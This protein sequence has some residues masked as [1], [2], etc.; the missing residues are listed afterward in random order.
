M[1]LELK[2]RNDVW[3]VHGTVVRPDGKR[4]RVRKSTGYTVHQK[5][6]ASAALSRILLE[7]MNAPPEAEVEND[8]ATLDDA[9]D[10]YL[11]RPNPPGQTE[12]GHLMRLSKAMGR[13][14]LSKV[15]LHSL[16]VYVTQR[17][18][19]PGT[20]AREMNSINA[21]LTHAKE[22]GM[23]APDFLLK[24]PHVDDARTRWLTET[25]RDRL[26]A[27]CPSEIAGLVT[28]LFLTGAR[29]GEAMD[30]TWL[31]VRDGCA[32]F[33]S[34]KGK[35]RKKRV[36]A[37]PLV[38]D[39]VAAMGARGDARDY[40]FAT[41]S[42][43]RWDRSNFYEHFKPA[44]ARAGI[45]DFK[46]HD[47]RHTFASHLIQKGASLRAV[48]DLLGHTS[49]AMV[50]RYTHFAP[51]HLSD[52]VHLLGA[53]GTNLTHERGN[54]YNTNKGLGLGKGEVESS[55]LSSSTIFPPK[56][57]KKHRK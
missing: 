35:M 52:T 55:I 10:A 11:S 27:E 47:C 13:T 31:D 22:V 17:G 3:Q 43:T 50:M 57:S 24:R 1:A 49:L 19:M 2:L 44:M 9:I 36:R 7:H 5:Q 46:T 8:A 53:I 20:V 41:P 14:V 32:Y 54:L 51:N 21:M 39:C 25:E 26:I 40:V 23:N 6:Y 12:R 45:E 34:Y 38:P 48:A 37:V 42:G 29:L 16:Y 28:F 30:L 56:T 33:T 18:N 15:Q 4:V